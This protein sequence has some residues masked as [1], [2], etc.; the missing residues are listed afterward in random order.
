MPGLHVRVTDLGTKVELT[1][2]GTR[3]VVVLGYAGE[4]YLRVG[5]KG[6]FENA[7]SPATYLNR[8]TTITGSPPKSADAKAAPVWRRV[9]TGT[10]ASWHDHRAHFMGGD[11]PPEVVRDP[12]Q[13]RVVDNWV[14]PMRV[15]STDVAAR[16]QLDLRAAAVAVAVGDRPRCCIAALV[17]VLS[18]T[19][20]WRTVFVVALALLTLTEAVHV[21]GLWDASTASFGTKLRRERLLAGRDRARPARPRVDLAQGRR[22]GGAAGARRHHLPVR[23]RR[24]RRR[25]QPRE[26]PG[27]EHV[28]GRVRAAARDVTLGLG[29]RAGGGGRVAA[30]AVVA[31]SPPGDAG[32]RPAASVTS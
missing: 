28:L 22:V 24:P 27:A 14:I 6:V 10:T 20:A 23:G 15:G 2:D 21:I 26:L 18:R 25:H 9:S 12:D 3:E 29:C 16:G 31:D 30:A 7:R 4:P 11:D 8:S 32:A 1:N 17:V 19:R 13:R 5:P